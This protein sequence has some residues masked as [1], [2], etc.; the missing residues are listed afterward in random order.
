M[1]KLEGVQQVMLL[2][3]MGKPSMPD[4]GGTSE[5]GKAEE[6]LDR[7]DLAVQADGWYDTH[8]EEVELSPD[9]SG[10]INL[11]SGTIAAYPDGTDAWRKVEQRG[12][13]LYDVDEDTYT[14][15]SSIKVKLEQR[16]EFAC[17]PTPI[18]RYIVALA[19][20]KYN[21]NPIRVSIIRAELRDA[22]AQARRYNTKRDP[23]TAF[24]TD[25]ARRVCGD[26]R[27]LRSF[28]L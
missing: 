18:Q 5:E 27:S 26:R 6:W 17:L 13:R 11:P 22:R 23:R 14:F 8:R 19:A 10:N 9:G 3:G 1:T 20:K 2:S 16:L 28:G 15:T 21:T 25:H 7:M 12:S 24:T 4:P